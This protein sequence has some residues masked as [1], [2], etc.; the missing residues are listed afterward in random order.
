MIIFGNVKI[1]ISF[2]KFVGWWGLT[3][4]CTKYKYIIIIS[5]TWLFSYWTFASENSQAGFNVILEEK[6]SEVCVSH[7]K[8]VS[9]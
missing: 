6:V 3:Y 9:L 1:S 2:G 7:R 5:L 8:W 4:L